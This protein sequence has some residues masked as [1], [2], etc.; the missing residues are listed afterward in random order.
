[1]KGW[2]KGPDNVPKTPGLNLQAGLTPH[3]DIP[4]MI[5]GPTPPARRQAGLGNTSLILSS[6]QESFL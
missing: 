3:R 6:W 1:L 2:D 4:E 5:A